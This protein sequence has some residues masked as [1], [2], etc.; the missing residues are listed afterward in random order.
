MFYLSFSVVLRSLL[1]EA[2]GRLVNPTFGSLGLFWTGEWAQCE[3][4]ICA[5][6]NG[7]IM[8]GV[9]PYDSHTSGT[10]GGNRILPTCDIRHV[11]KGNNE[12][13]VKGKNGFKRVGQ[14]IKPKPQVGSVDSALLWKP[15]WESESTEA[16]EGSSISQEKLNLEL[17]LGFRCQSL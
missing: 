6:L 11:S 4:A 17:T 15:N 13:G 7:S 10:L 8:N 2:C 16:V 1:Y 12:N 3:A 9:T 14:V 5:V